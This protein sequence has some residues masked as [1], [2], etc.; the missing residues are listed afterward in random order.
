[1]SIILSP[2]SSD[3]D[4]RNIVVPVSPSITTFKTYPLVTN[5]LLSGPIVQMTPM[6]PSYYKFDV[7]TG[8]NDN[9]LAQKEM[10]DYLLDRILKYWIKESDMKNVLKFMKVENDKVVLVKN[11][12]EYEKNNSENDRT[13]DIMKKSDFLKE[14]FLNRENMRKI[15]IEIMDELKWKWKDLA[16]PREEKV[17]L[18]VT[19][20]F[21]K[22]QLRK[23]IKY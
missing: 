11:A 9:W 4:L 8:L 21:L 20:K 1:M 18:G 13:S 23:M 2:T 5:P 12:D 6:M 15:L 14:N 16:Q 10:T 19:K 22:K 7:D 17:V 3:I